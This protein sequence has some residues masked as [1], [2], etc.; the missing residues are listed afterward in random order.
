MKERIK[1]FLDKYLNK[2]ISR[3]LMVFIVGTVLLC[4]GLI[5]AEIWL[6]LASIYIT[7]EGAKDWTVAH[8]TTKAIKS[9]LSKVLVPILEEEDHDR[10]D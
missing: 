9:D 4:V 5:N 2:F 6:T 10:K 1:S 8:N 3:K 7:V